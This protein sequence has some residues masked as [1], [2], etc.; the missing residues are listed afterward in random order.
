MQNII[1]EILPMQNDRHFADDVL[2]PKCLHFYWYFPALYCHGILDSLDLK[3]WKVQVICIHFPQC[4]IF[5]CSCGCRSKGFTI[6]SQGCWYVGNE[7]PNVSSSNCMYYQ[8]TY[9]KTSGISRTKSPNPGS[10]KR[11]THGND[12]LQPCMD[13]ESS[14]GKHPDTVFQD[15]SLQTTRCLNWLHKISSPEN[16]DVF[17]QI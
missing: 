6:K 5:R 3:M 13:P 1:T 7:G 14:A 4:C 12:L 9:R 11:W 8:P 16:I 2:R 10:Y 15:A 17:R